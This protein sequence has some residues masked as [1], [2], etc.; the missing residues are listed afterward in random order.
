MLEIF[1]L[2]WGLQKA[3]HS[4]SRKTTT[5]RGDMPD[6]IKMPEPRWEEGQTCLL[7]PELKHP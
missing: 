2:Y 5:K 4:F 7:N 3:T 1:L 6:V